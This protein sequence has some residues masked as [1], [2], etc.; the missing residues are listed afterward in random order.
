V[1]AALSLT[2]IVCVTAL[3]IPVAAQ[4]ETASSASAKTRE[5]AIQGPV[6]KTLAREAIRLA[7]ERPEVGK[8]LASNFAR[9]WSSVGKGALV[10]FGI[11][12]AL[13]MTVGQEACLH[14]PRWH[15][16]KVG[17]PFA[18]I[19]AAIAWLHK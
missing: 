5:P 7:A 9:T 13:G 16:T 2:L 6:A 19:G 4:D 14:E 12:A 1:K 10:G 8:P 11:G 17:L 15:C 18:A 3:V